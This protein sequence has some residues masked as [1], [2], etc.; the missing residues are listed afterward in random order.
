MFDC[1]RSRWVR[2][3]SLSPFPRSVAGRAQL[4]VAL[5]TA[6]VLSAGPRGWLLG[7]LDESVLDSDNLPDFSVRLFSFLGAHAAAL[8]RLWWAGHRGGRQPGLSRATATAGIRDFAKLAWPMRKLAVLATRA[9]TMPLEL[10][11]ELRL[12]ENWSSLQ[13]CGRVGKGANAKVSA[14]CAVPAHASAA[15][16]LACLGLGNHC[17]SKVELKRGRRA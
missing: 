1:C 9:L 14:T 10:R 11:A 13:L 2:S 8:R 16:Q 5:T 15:K 17:G 6:L 4:A 7:Q 12:L 3:A